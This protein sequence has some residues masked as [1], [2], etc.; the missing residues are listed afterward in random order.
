MNLQRLSQQ[1][2]LVK[3]A[4]IEL[5]PNS[6]MESWTT[7]LAFLS[8]LLTRNCAAAPTILETP[9]KTEMKATDLLEDATLTGI[10]TCILL[11]NPA[12]ARQMEI[13]KITHRRG[14]AS[15]LYCAMHNYAN[16]IVGLSYDARYVIS[17]ERHQL[18][19]RE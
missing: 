4:V 5:H 14:D 6:C 2:A 9:K 11:T 10:S 7:N 17:S 19:R 12:N 15:A 8:S 1:P 18:L 3:F 16:K 13:C